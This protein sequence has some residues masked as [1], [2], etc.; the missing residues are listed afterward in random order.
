MET[1]C[2]SIF[3]PWRPRLPVAALCLGAV[4]SSAGCGGPRLVPVSGSV[5]ME[6]KPVVGA[7]VLFCPADKGPT[8]C[9][10]TDSAGRFQLETA[11]K[12]GAMPGR[13]RVAV[14]KKQVLGLDKFGRVGPSGV[15]VN[16]HVPE[17]YGSFDTSGLRVVVDR[18]SR[19]FNFVLSGR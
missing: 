5:Q 17:K 4:L 7:S 8:A 6:G 1:P 3:E 2:S 12:P 10:S 14:I 16:W 13:Y 19:E 15:H 9:A 18:D 11:S